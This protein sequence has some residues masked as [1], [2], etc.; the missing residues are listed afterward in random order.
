MPESVE[1]YSS[2]TYARS[3]AMLPRSGTTRDRGVVDATRSFRGQIPIPPQSTLTPSA[4]GP[5][6]RLQPPWLSVAESPSTV[7]LAR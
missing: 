3:A 4:R 5:D 7:R 1:T 2:N 6:P